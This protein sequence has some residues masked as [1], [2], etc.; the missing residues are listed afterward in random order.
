M[1]EKGG[2]YTWIYIKYFQQNEV[3][4]KQTILKPTLKKK[5]DKYPVVFFAHQKYSSAASHLGIVTRKL[6]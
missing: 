2:K 1:G 6:F 3:Y 5:N 4:Y